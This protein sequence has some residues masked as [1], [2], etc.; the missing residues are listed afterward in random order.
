MSIGIIVF[1]EVGTGKSTLCNTLI[2]KKNAFAESDDVN[3]ETLET[4]AKDGVYKGQK[5]H[6]IDTPGMGHAK[7][8]DA[9]HLVE[10]A[11][12]LKN[13][14][15]IQAIVMT[16]NY[17]SPR[18]EEREKSLLTIIRNAFPN[19][20]W[21]K[22]IAFVHTHVYRYIP[23]DKK[24]PKILQKKKEG[25][26][27][28]MKQFFPEINYEYIK[29]IPQIFIDSF[30]ARESSNDSTIQVCELLEWASGLKP[31]NQELP[32]MSVPIEEPQQETRIRKECAPSLKIWHKGQKTLFGLIGRSAYNE[33][34][35]QEYVITEERTIQKMTDGSIK[36][37]KDWHEIK[38][39]T[40][41]AK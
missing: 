11:R 21:F 41:N 17:H 3:A 38:R 39:Y 30:D 15:K 23:E 24:T 20:E 13:D 8:L 18:F 6:V 28:K 2:S 9:S 35:P 26:I 31:L 19:S 4:I 33:Y 32:E 14:H 37:I 12:Y 29:A 1:G 36:L 5:V 22:H 40:K 7:S 10:I 16:F 27:K 25:I 34:I